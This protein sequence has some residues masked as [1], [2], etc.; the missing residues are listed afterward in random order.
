MI[1]LK[2]SIIV[3]VYNVE[4]YL[5]KCLNSIAKQSYEN[6]EVIIVNDGTKD[7]SQ[8]IIDKYT[9][10]DERFK[11]YIKE[12]GGLSSARNYGLKYVTGD[13]LLF[14]DSD[15]YLD[16]NLLSQLNDTLTRN[17][18]DL[19]RFNCCVCDEEGHIISKSNDMAYENQQVDKIISDL[20]RRSFVEPAWLYCYNVKFWEK[21]QFSYAVSKIHEDFGL[22]PLILSYAE[23]I[24]SINYDGYYYVQR[25][26]SITK[27][28]DYQKI[29]KAAF[30]LLDQYEN[31]VNTLDKE[32]PSFVRRAI[33]TYV[34]E[35]VILKMRD[36]NKADT[37][38]YLKTIKRLKTVKRI[39]PYNSKKLVK[40]C[41][42]MISLKL[43]IKIFD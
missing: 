30:D 15:D 29:R 36:L 16:I 40:R 18:V 14:V 32:E 22:T 4:K 7:N 24:T 17:K 10:K 26:G 31:I 8:K 1:K 13:Y 20:M 35:C 23:S 2:Y 21:Y 6:F 12:N 41:I 27:T 37:Q 33:M 43:Y 11:G 34:S 3:P 9:K 19:V 25:D 39:N 5:D 38:E 28:K 42:A